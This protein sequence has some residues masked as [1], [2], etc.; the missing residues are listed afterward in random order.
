MYFNFPFLD[1]IIILVSQYVKI[2][3]QKFKMFTLSYV[4]KYKL[5]HVSS[6]KTNSRNGNLSQTLF[7]Q[8]NLFF[9]NN[10]Y[11]KDD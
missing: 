7:Q 1:N 11:Y 5:K 4:F 3:K 6:P 8:K 2:L 9:K 10:T